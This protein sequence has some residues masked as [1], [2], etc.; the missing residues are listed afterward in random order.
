VAN[1]AGSYDYVVQPAT[2]TQI[3]ITLQATAA[4]YELYLQGLPQ[5]G[6]TV[7]HSITGAEDTWVEFGT[8]VLASVS[9]GAT[10]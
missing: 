6:G 4:N 2:V 9:P 1:G 7:T 8:V 3:G 5:V 10:N